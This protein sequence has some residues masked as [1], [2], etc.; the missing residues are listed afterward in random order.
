MGEDQAGDRA[1]RLV[2]T[3][4]ASGSLYAQAISG[5][6]F[7]IMLSADTEYPQRLVQQ[8][9]ASERDRHA[10]AVGVLVIW[11]P[12]RM[13]SQMQGDPLRFLGE[14]T[15]ER[16]AIANPRLAPYGRAA[17]ET[18]ESAELM[19]RVAEKISWGEN[20]TQAAHFA[21]SRAADAAFLPL[22]LA[23]SE[24]L[25][26]AGAYWL[27]EDRRY[28]PITQAGVVLLDSP[29]H[30]LACEVFAQFRADMESGLATRN[31]YRPVG[32]SLMPVGRGQ[33]KN[34]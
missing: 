13:A 18:L 4:G 19:E 34:L 28:Q 9:R 12:H 32:T 23:S 22:S 2:V 16:I 15:I 24:P 29:R 17:V 8:G 33:A 25:K 31:G 20:V 7:D 3:Y 11:M 6:P 1:P 14:P 26:S 5:A 10:Y 30:A 21:Y 27:V